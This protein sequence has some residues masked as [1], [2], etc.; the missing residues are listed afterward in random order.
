MYLYRWT[1]REWLACLMVGWFFGG[2]YWDAMGVRAPPGF[3]GVPVAVRR[4]RV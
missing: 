4:V 3:E 2:A 1:E